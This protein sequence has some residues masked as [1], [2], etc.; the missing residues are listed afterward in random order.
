M[1]LKNEAVL[2]PLGHVVPTQNRDGVIWA[3]ACPVERIRTKPF[4]LGDPL[5]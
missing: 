5:I 4:A 3:N 2:V 1:N